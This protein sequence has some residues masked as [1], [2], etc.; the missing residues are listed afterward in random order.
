L[1]NPLL[2]FLCFLSSCLKNRLP[3]REAPA[4]HDPAEDVARAA[5]GPR[6]ISDSS[7]RAIEPLAAAFWEPCF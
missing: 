1:R 4:L 5:D 7:R 6:H 3:A 2:L